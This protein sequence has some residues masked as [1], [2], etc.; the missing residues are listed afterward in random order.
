M[1]GVRS[2]PDGGLALLII[3]LQNAYF[4][5]PELAAQQD[6]LIARTNELVREA[7]EHSRPIV[8][9]RT[10]HARDKST[11]TINM[12]DDDQGFAFPGTEQAAHL[13][14]LELDGATDLV[15][16]RDDAFHGTRLRELLDELGVGHLL[17]AGVSTHSCVAETAMSG[18]AH[19]FR[20]TIA[21]DA[22]ASENAVLSEAMLEFLTDELRQP[23]LDQPASLAL[24]RD[25]PVFDPRSR[26]TP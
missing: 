8:A 18:F 1:A 2:D 13:A 7:R 15:K 16:T 17:I 3:D 26:N 12:L 20:V 4:E 21:A 5:A 24:L 11:W 6:S 22:I 25:G 10:E 19:D 14:G 9:A 23:V